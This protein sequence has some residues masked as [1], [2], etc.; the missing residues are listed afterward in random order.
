ME[1]QL[2]LYDDM[3]DYYDKVGHETPEVALAGTA[4]HNEVYKDGALSHKM[5]RLMSLAI[6]LQ[7]RCGECVV[8][9]TKHAVDAGATKAEILETVAV[10][11]VI[12]GSLA[13]ASMWRVVRVLEEMGKW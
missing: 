2:K 7:A 5:K 1:S 9:H 8:G 12:G 3:V 10:A 11:T 4:Y 13:G 6:A